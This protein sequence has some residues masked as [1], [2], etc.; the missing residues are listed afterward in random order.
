[1]TDPLLQLLQN[2]KGRGLL[3]DTNILLMYF[4]GAADPHLIGTFKRTQQFVLEDLDLLHRMFNWF[5]TVVT[6]PNILTEVNNLASQLPSNQAR[7]WRHEFRNRV[8]TLSEEYLS[9]QHVADKPQYLNCG[10]TDTGVIEASRARLLVLTDDLHLFI[11]LQSE[12]IDAI[13]FNHLRTSNWTH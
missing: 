10:L 11:A 5:G 3:V 12:G 8:S 1:M 2:Y 7:S 4:V 9:S 13:N 6:T